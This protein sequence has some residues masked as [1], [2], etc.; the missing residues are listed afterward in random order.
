MYLFRSI[1]QMIAAY[2]SVDELVYRDVD[3]LAKLV[4]FAAER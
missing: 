4:N 3:A 1:Q 2:Q